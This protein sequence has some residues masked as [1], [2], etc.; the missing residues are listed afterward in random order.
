MSSEAVDMTTIRLDKGYAWDQA[1]KGRTRDAG[2]GRSDGLPRKSFKLLVH[3]QF[4]YSVLCVV[5]CM[6]GRGAS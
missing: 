5:L 4:G 3:S 1:K 2:I 6:A